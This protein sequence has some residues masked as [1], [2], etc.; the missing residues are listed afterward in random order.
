MRGA[1]VVQRTERARQ[2]PEA[3]RHAPRPRESS[4]AAEASLQEEFVNGEKSAMT[5]ERIS[6]LREVGDLS[7]DQRSGR[8]DGGNCEL[9]I[10]CGSEGGGYEEEC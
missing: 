1:E 10:D 4:G 2:G 7:F 8:D 6:K 9:N 3:G 5:E